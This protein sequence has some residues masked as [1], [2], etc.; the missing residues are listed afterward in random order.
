MQVHL[1]D[2]GH[3]TVAACVCSMNAGT[4]DLSAS[5]GNTKELPL[6]LIMNANFTAPSIY[7]FLLSLSAAELAML[8]LSCRPAQSK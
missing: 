4:H 8:L 2:M 6:A 3:L 5:Q 1:C 7:F